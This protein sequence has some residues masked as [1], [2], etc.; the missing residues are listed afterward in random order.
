MRF[1]VHLI[2]EARE[3]FKKLDNSQ[4]IP[5]AKQLKKLESNPYK[6]KPLGKKYEI[7][8]SGYYKLYAVKKQIRIIYTVKRSQIT[9][10]VITIG[11]REDSIVY[12][13]AFKR[14]KGKK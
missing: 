10:E 2:E 3:D 5:V 6:G 13:E 14:T 9:V 1:N 4:K 11:A 8:L 7:D 12:K